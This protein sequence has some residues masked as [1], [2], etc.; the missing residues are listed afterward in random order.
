MAP[1]KRMCQ[2]NVPVQLRRIEF[3]D[4]LARKAPASTIELATDAAPLSNSV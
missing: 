1:P 3:D 2:L 4:A